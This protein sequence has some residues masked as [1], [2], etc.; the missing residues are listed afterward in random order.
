MAQAINQTTTSDRRG[1]PL[2]TLFTDPIVAA[3]FRRAEDDGSLVVL[4]V[5]PRPLTD[6]AAE[7]ME[8]CD[9]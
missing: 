7:K 5:N 9:A 3:A 6:S 1:L 2:S 4:P 8:L